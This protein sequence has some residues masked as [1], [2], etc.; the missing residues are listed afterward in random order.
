MTICAVIHT[1]DALSRAKY[2]AVH[3]SA[4]N[5]RQSAV[6]SNALQRLQHLEVIILILDAHLI[7]ISVHFLKVFKTVHLQYFL[8]CSE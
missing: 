4:L 7:F 5:I 3:R 2:Y 1:A 6:L 8:V